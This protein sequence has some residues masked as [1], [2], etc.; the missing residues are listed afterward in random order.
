MWTTNIY[1]LNQTLLANRI[2]ARASGIVETIANALAYYQPQNTVVQIE[3]IDPTGR[4]I[5]KVDNQNQ[6]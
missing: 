2:N 1:D 5:I 4:L 3:M 6:E